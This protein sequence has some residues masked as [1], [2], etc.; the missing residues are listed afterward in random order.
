MLYYVDEIQTSFANEP[1]VFKTFL[2]TI[3]DFK[4]QVIDIAQVL[5]RVVDLFYDHGQIEL[6]RTVNLL[7]PEK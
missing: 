4:N 3:M 7:L 2:A 1:D 6:L 5:W